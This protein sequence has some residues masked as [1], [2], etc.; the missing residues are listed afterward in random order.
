MTL[1]QIYK[2]YSVMKIFNIR[3]GE[4]V[5]TALDR[6]KQAMI[7]IE[8]GREPT[9]YFGAG[10]ETMSQLTK[11]F[12]PT[13]WDLIEYLKKAGAMSIYQLAKELGRDYRNV[14]SDV[15]TLLERSVIKKDEDDK[16]YMPWDKIVV[17]WPILKDAA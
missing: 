13:R 3:I 11:I 1:C 4:A 6:A 8:E 12:T 15:Q 9:E 14:H 16:I 2:R 7:D 17:D 5:E 10:F